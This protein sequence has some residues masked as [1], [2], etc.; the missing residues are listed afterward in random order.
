MEKILDD[1][2]IY[3]TFFANDK[4]ETVARSIFSTYKSDLPV[5][6]GTFNNLGLTI[7]FQETGS[8][9]GK[10]IYDFLKSQELSYKVTYN[11]N[12]NKLYFTVY[13]GLDRTQEQ[14]VN[15]YIVFS[16]KYYNLIDSTII[17]D[18]SNFK[19][20]AIVGGQGEGSDRIYYHADLS[21]GGYKKTIFV[22][23]R[24]L[25]WDQAHGQTLA[26]YQANL[27]QRGIEKLSDFVKIQNINFRVLPESYEY[28]VDYDLGDKINIVVDSLGLNL[29]ARIIAIDEVFKNGQQI[30]ELEIGNQLI[31]DFE[32]SR[33]G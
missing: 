32:K 10:K 31:T 20:Y 21:G 2:I 16:T 18:D 15:N 8:E 12:E 1:K 33:W 19:N 26:Q 9:M 11:F 17:E 14:T 29:Q 28:M 7:N 22:D 23:A 5:Y 6:L 24:D 25:T 30:I 13:Q 27:T 3:P 4:A